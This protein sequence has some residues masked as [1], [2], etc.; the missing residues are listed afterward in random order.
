MINEIDHC[1]WFRHR[2]DCVRDGARECP[3]QRF[4]NEA[5]ESTVPRHDA[6]PSDARRVTFHRSSSSVRTISFH[7]FHRG[8]VRN[9]SFHRHHHHHHRHHHH[10]HF[11]RANVRIGGGH[12]A[13]P[14]RLHSPRL[15]HNTRFSPVSARGAEQPAAGSPP[16]AEHPAPELEKPSPAQHPQR[17]IGSFT[18]IDNEPRLTLRPAQREPRPFICGRGLTVKSL[19]ATQG[20]WVRFPPSAPALSSPSDFSPSGGRQKNLEPARKKRKGGRLTGAR[21]WNFPLPPQR[22][23]RK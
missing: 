18:E 7:R 13:T 23:L 15:T 21:G 19:S 5:H 10:H 14:A 2:P 4:A 3:C 1:P 6:T 17:M 12:R 22:E 11:A 16:G 20:V 9:V 8:S